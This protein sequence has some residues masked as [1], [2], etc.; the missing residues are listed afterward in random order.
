MEAL[1]HV[2]GFEPRHAGAFFSYMR[3]ILL[4]KVRDLLRQAARRPRPGALD[5]EIVAWGP[6]PLESAVGTETL[7]TY[8]QA[9]AGLTTEQ[10]EAVVMRIEMGFTY[11]EIAAALGSPT[12]NAARML[13]SRGLV[14]LVEILGQ[15]QVNAR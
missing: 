6:S 12:A 3:R 13:V 1:D 5:E 14:R 10:Q 11:P 2:K 15:S 9:L 7:A 4:N 8:E